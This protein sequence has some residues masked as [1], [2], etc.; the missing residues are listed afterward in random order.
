MYPIQSRIES[1]GT[2]VPTVEES[3]VT[4]QPATTPRRQQ[5]QDRLV[6]AGIAVIARHGVRGASVEE[7]CESAGFTRGAF[8]SNFDSK[9]DLCLAILEHL[10]EAYLDAARRA[11]AS[12]VDSLADRI[13]LVVDVFTAASGT[14]ADSILVM[15]E[16]RLYAAREESMRRAFVEFNAAA[17]PLFEQ[18]V[19]DGLAAAGLKLRMPM[20]R[21]IALLQAVH[22]Q[23]GLEQLITHG[24]PNPAQASE[25][26][27]LVIETMV[28]PA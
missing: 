22:D 12:V 20:P 27:A 10:G 7:I 14:D 15:N 23:T 26:L 19:A 28:E 18:V 6:Q 5:T 13:Q 9:D 1:Q 4:S 17:M 8:Y 16:L 2:P 24:T 25:A 21:A 3:T 11:V